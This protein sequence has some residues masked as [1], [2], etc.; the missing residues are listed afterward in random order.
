MK[1]LREHFPKMFSAL[2]LNMGLG[3]ALLDLRIAK[4]MTVKSKR[5]LLLRDINYKELFGVER[6]L[7]LHPC[8]FDKV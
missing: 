8:Y 6:A 1:W 3:D 7:E 4:N 5:A 2:M